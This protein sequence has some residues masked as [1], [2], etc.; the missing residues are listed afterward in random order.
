MGN[1]KIV[2]NLCDIDECYLHVKY[3]KDLDEIREVI[4]GIEEFEPSDVGITTL[5]T[6]IRLIKL[7]DM[8]PYIAISR[9]GI[10]DNDH[11]SF[12]GPAG[13]FD[14]IIRKQDGD[15]VYIE[16]N[17]VINGCAEELYKFGYYNIDVIKNIPSNLLSIGFDPTKSKFIIRI[18]NKI[19]Y[20]TA[21][22]DDFIRDFSNLKISTVYGVMTGGEFAQKMNDKFPMNL[23]NIVIALSIK[24]RNK[25]FACRECKEFFT[26]IYCESD[27]GKYPQSIVNAFNFMNSTNI[28]KIT[29]T[30]HDR[31]FVANSNM[32][33]KYIW[34]YNGV[35][36][37]KHSS[38]D[39][40][41]AGEI[42]SCS[43]D[44]KELE[45]LNSEDVY[46]EILKLEI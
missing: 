27:D 20:A 37:W 32:I 10:L 21:N 39:L 25:W 34:V 29:F 14:F 24:N 8:A 45:K 13:D 28:D 7:K 26:D 23:H 41:K 9:I 35:L 40:S 17:I 33:N 31:I 43:R 46:S 19:T 1:C 36:Y 16:A 2:N 18:N 11:D 42:L 15:V 44:L 22:Y 3:L 5:K 30:L 38:A 6:G 12:K 4:P